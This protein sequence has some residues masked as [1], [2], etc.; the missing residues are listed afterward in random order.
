MRGLLRLAGWGGLAMAAV[1]L[2]VIAANSGRRPHWFTD[3][4]ANRAEEAA[5]VKVAA[6]QAAQLKRLAVTEEETRRLV[7]MVRVLNGDRERLL[8]RVSTLERK[9]EDV[10]GSIERQAKA[11]PAVP[12]P[13]TPPPESLPKIAAV[14]PPAAQAEPRVTAPPSV[15][16][17]PASNS[18]P[19]PSNELD[20]QQPRP[21]AGVDIGGATNFDGLR[22]LWNAVTTAHAGLFEGLHPIVTVRENNKSRAADLR[23]IAG[24]LTDLESATRICTAL[25]AAK[26]YCRLVTF[27]GHPL[28]LVAP[29]PPA[30]PA[31]LI[32]RPAP[33]PVAPRSAP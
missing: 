22:T 32:K 9:L 4:Q 20:A 16:S 8:T 18:T 31:A 10:T 23:L 1:L 24:P 12:P 14:P 11:A 2:A 30:R 25:A 26:H 27:E 17:R 28:A 19:G 21:A 7:E 29:E 3:P 33:R 6:V 5:K 15:P 13:A